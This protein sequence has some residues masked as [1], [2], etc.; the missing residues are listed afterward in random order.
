MTRRS[1]L[2]ALA[3]LLVACGQ[4]HPANDAG[5]VGTDAGVPPPCDAPS[6]TIVVQSDLEPG[7]EAVSIVVELN[8]VVTL[9]VGVTAGDDLVTGLEIGTL[10]GLVHNSRIV[11]RILDAVG[12]ERANR[13]LTVDMVEDGSTL[14]FVLSRGG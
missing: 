8:D 4:S 1:A 13:L 12:A 11:V 2:P 10:C 14:V 5:P 9:G 6:A 3:F 7:T